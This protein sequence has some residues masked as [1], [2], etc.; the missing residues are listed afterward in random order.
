MLHLV[1]NLVQLPGSQPQ[2]ELAKVHGDV[3][4][5]LRLARLQGLAQLHGDLVTP[6]R[7]QHRGNSQQGGARHAA[8]HHVFT[9][10]HQVG[11]VGGDVQHIGPVAALYLI[12]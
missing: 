10:L 5:D 3:L 2:G 4:G 8:D 9:D 12:Q 1:Q 6:V 7:C 11:V